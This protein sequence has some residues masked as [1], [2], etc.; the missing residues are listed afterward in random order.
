MVVAVVQR[1]G[2]VQQRIPVGD[3][4]AGG[5]AHAAFDRGDVLPGNRAALDGVD[6]DQAFVVVGLDLQIDVPE[7]SAAAGL[8]HVAALGLGR[9]GDRLAVGHLRDAGVHLGFEFAH[10][11][12]ED[13]L[14][15]Q[16]AHA[17]QDGLAGLGV[18]LDD[19]RRVFGRQPL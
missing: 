1:D 12:V 16:F 14:Q 2:R 6:E 15:V 3:A 13:H 10:E 17:R 19:Q 18:G 5:L 9:A 4:V 7:L 11:A 8:A